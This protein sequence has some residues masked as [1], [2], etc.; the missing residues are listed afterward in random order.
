MLHEF[1]GGRQVSY[2]VNPQHGGSVETVSEV[3]AIDYFKELGGD[4]AKSPVVPSSPHNASS[5]SGGSGSNGAS[6]Q[7]R[8]RRRVQ[9]TLE[10]IFLP[11]GYPN[12]VTDDL[13]TFALWDTA[14]VLANSVMAALSMRAVLLGVGVG[15]STANLTSSTLSWMMR[16]GMWLLGSLF[17]ASVISQDLEFRAKTWRLVADFTNDTATF[18]ELCVPLF[19]G[20]QLTFRLVV[21]LASLIKALV[22]VC[23]SGTRASFTQH[24][25]LRSNAADVAAKAGMR[26]NVGGLVGL[27]LGMVVA[28][29][30]PASSTVLNLSVFVLSTTFHLV[31]NYK[32]V[33]GVQLR[34]LN[35][36]R[37]EWCCEQFC[38]FQER[39]LIAR[40]KETVA[41]AAMPVLD[42]SVR[43]AN[44]EE[45]LF[46]LPALPAV[47]LRDAGLTD[48][49]CVLLRRYL[50]PPTLQ[51][52]LHC[53]ASFH[54]LLTAQTGLTAARKHALVHRVAESLSSRGVALL[55]DAAAM[56]YYVILPE[57]YTVEGVPESWVPYKRQCQ[58]DRE[59]KAKRAH[60]HRE[61]SAGADAG[62]AVDKERE[63]EDE[64]DD[65]DRT[66]AEA[67]DA[68]AR[69]EID[70][71]R[72]ERVVVP[73]HVLPLAY[74]ELWAFFYA[75]MHHR[76]VRE[77]CKRG[78]PP[79]RASAGLPPPHSEIDTNAA[80]PECTTL[81]LIT[82]LRA[83][84]MLGENEEEGEQHAG[85]SS[86]HNAPTAFTMVDRD[87]FEEM[88]SPTSTTSSKINA[89]PKKAGA[90]TTAAAGASIA[91]QD[92]LYPLF[93]EFVRGL[94]KTGWELDRLLL[95][96]EGCTTVVHYL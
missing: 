53:G 84:G 60:R 31:A 41:K 44:A 35:A 24:F 75:Y 39:A 57:F 74:R 76:V 93:I 8:L 36:P 2:R 56:S 72:R 34:H 14:Q 6:R 29:L 81:H 28:Y 25:A 1:S 70:R 42:L 37:L 13:L 96:N 73:P 66:A 67:A 19:P 12:S 85:R 82:H 11:A 16:D 20:G 10:R 45:P 77:R 61:G 71:L 62:T 38:L 15:E 47:P 27:A 3:Y 22:S 40:K 78:R 9:A 65:D 94:R 26:G 86:E 64:D 92:G 5:H 50:C 32:G 83:D 33:R 43:R 80:S 51:L 52:R 79:L 63:D 48:R 59:A 87:M 46:I 90:E 17:F 23:G 7:R 49:V 55:L 18:L 21:V 30:V 88:T 58:A 89:F 69:A 4:V 54:T 91:P 68:E 95:D